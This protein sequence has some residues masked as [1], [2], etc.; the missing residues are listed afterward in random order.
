VST[1]WFVVLS[2]LLYTSYLTK[3]PLQVVF[4]IP[5]GEKINRWV[6]PMVDDGVGGLPLPLAWKYID[7]IGDLCKGLERP[8]TS[9]PQNANS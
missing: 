6:Y 2:G 7:L 9:E 5:A 3:E 8:A 1:Q 4:L